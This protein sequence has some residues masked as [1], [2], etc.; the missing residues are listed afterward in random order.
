MRIISPF[1]DYYDSVNNITS[2]KDAL[3]IRKEEEVDLYKIL[4]TDLINAL[5]FKETGRKNGLSIDICSQ[6]VLF[7]GKLYGGLNIEFGKLNSNLRPITYNNIWSLE[8]FDKICVQYPE[9]ELHKSYRYDWKNR[10]YSYLRDILSIQQDTRFFTWSIENKISI[11]YFEGHLHSLPTFPK[12]GIKNYQLSKIEFQK[13]LDPYVAYQ[14]LD[15]WIGGT[16]SQNK[17]P[18]AISDNVKIQQ[19][20][21]DKNSFRKHYSENKK[22]SKKLR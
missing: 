15:M 19:H 2:D 4:P 3:F 9:L 6:F 5:Y 8:E 7:C 14:E 20:G 1:K 13:V 18:E 11:L 12:T 17:E 10:K 22:P 16:L 21:F